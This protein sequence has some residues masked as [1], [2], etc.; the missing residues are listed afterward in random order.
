MARNS[1]GFVFGGF[2]APRYTPTPDQLFDELLA[3]GLLTEAELRVLLYIVRRTFGWKKDCDD[4]S[5]SQITRGIV[6]R[7]GT[8]L[9]W[10]AGV[11]K[12]T[13]VRAIKGL[14]EKGVIV[15]THNYREDGGDDTKSYTLRVKDSSVY[16][17][18]MQN[19]ATGN[20]GAPGPDFAPVFHGRTR[21]GI[22]TEQGGFYD[23]TPRGSAV[24]PGVFRNGT[25]AGR[26]TKQ[27]PV[28]RRDTQESSVQKTSRQERDDSN[29]PSPV[30]KNGSSKT[31][32]AHDDK[33]ATRPPYSPYIASVVSDFSAELGDAEHSV[34]NVTQAL[35]LWQRSALSEDE[36]VQR[37]YEAKAQTRSYQGKHGTRGIEN[38]MAYFFAVLTR[39][40]SNS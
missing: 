12:S 30:R 6:R 16:E 5:L 40:L 20:T 34:S 22:A 11:A 28:A 19:S 29:R 7:D 8:R 17:P 23:E 24:E 10:G 32:G 18:T 21:G 14:V 33:D 27:S 4:I 2:D 25:G 35:R 26:T 15:A 9:D 36:F 1:G 38:K 31:D 13:A 3:P 39:V 37:M